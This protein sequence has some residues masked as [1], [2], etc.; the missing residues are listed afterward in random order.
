MSEQERQRQNNVVNNNVVKLDEN[1]PL[2]TLSTNYLSNINT[3]MKDTISSFCFR[4]EN[5]TTD[6]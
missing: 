6:D 1:R 4:E 5:P 2:D 3:P